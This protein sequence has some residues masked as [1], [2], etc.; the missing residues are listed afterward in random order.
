MFD[1]RKI[2]KRKQPF[3]PTFLDITKT[4]LHGNLEVGAYVRVVKADSKTKT[5][6]MELEM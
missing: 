5:S 2:R 4:R 6:E 1:I 3:V